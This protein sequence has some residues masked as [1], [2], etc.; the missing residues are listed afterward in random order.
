MELLE[1]A[2]QHDP[3]FALAYCD[4]AKAQVDLFLRPTIQAP[5]VAKK[6][7][8]AALR[9]RPDLGE[10]HLELA[11][12]Y[13]YANLHTSNFDQALDELAIA[14][15]KLP[16]NSEAILIGARIDRHQNRWDASLADFQKASELDPRN[17]EVGWRLGQT[18]FQMRRY[19]EWEQLLTKDAGSGLLDPWTQF[20][21]AEIKLAQGDPVGGSISSRTSAAR[22]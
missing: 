18:Y 3:N 12:Y 5:R 9:V 2:T 19:K 4:L 6:A 13:Y 21:L 8:E 20:L 22:L 17:S 7:A 14:R 10:A 11:R 15:R 16:N 1:K